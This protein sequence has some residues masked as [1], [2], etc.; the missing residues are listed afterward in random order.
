MATGDKLGKLVCP[1][2]GGAWE[3]T[4]MK[5]GGTSLKCE[6]GFVGWA[7]GPRSNAGIVAQLK[8]ASSSS[9]APAAKP[10]PAPAAKPAPAKPRKS[11]LATLLDGDDE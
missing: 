9:S 11:L 3:A 5:G 8:P 7:K 1:C 4:E 2:C 6:R 10:A